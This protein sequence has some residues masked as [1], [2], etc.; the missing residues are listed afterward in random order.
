MIHNFLFLL[1]GVFIESL[2]QEIP[3]LAQPTE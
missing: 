2:E 3:Q 1:Q